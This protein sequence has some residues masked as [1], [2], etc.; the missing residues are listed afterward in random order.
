MTDTE[1]VQ[2][3]IKANGDCMSYSH[4]DRG[5]DCTKCPLVAVCSIGTHTDS[6]T[7]T[8]RKAKKW[9][10]ANPI[11]LSPDV[12]V[13]VHMD[14]LYALASHTAKDTPTPQTDPVEHPAHYTKGGIECI[15]GIRSALTDEEFRGFCKGNVLKYIWRERSKN[16]IED[17]KKSRWYLDK[18][19]S[20]YEEASNGV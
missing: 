3:L 16:G 13:S 8:V 5:F 1:K 7:A 15:D 6:S 19:I 10:A 12:G 18:L 4:A 17:L 14:E 20:T 11:V 9:L 2:W